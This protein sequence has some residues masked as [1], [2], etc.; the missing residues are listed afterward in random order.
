VTRFWFSDGKSLPI[1]KEAV[2]KVKDTVETAASGTAEI[3][4][5]GNG[6]LRIAPKSKLAF[7]K[8]DLVKDSYS[9]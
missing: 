1:E 6:M 8:S 2:M 9:F 7:K 4:F 3:I 5:S